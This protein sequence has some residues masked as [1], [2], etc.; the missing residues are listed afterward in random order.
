[1]IGNVASLAGDKIKPLDAVLTLLVSA[2]GV[3][4]MTFFVGGTEID[5]ETVEAG[6]PAIPLVLLITAPLLLRR[7]APLHALTLSIGGMAIHGLLWSD[8]YRCGP[9][10]AIAFLLSY[11]VAVRSEL[12]DALLGLALAHVLCMVMAASGDGTTGLV[13]QPVIPMLWAAG[14]FVRSRN[15][16]NVELDSRTAELR[17][18]RDERARLE[19]SVDRARLSA[20]LDELLTR[21][22]SELARLADA[23][24]G[25]R[26]ASAAAGTLAEIERASRSTLE[27]MREIVGVLRSDNGSA[28]VAPPPTLAHLEALLLRAGGDHARLKVTGDPRALPA[29]VEL[30]AYRVVEHLL[31]AL[32]AAPDVGVEIAFADDA[33]GLTVSGTPRRRGELGPAVERA[34]ERV[35]LHRGTLSATTRGGRAEAVATLPVAIPAAV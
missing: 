29:G 1:M 20:E 4:V 33:V 14:R 5:G 16:M 10:Y 2:F 32:D 15:R 22:L 18:A 11:S 19:V 21:R 24:A 6:W 7:V 27:E 25:E 12:R 8:I 30:S 17:A 26:D 9:V 28:A 13:L 3:Y 31:D 34:R 23:G 35:Q